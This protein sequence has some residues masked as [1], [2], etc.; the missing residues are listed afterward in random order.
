MGE[1]VLQFTSGKERLPLSTVPPG[2]KL[3][4]YPAI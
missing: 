4:I 1:A 2:D 3:A